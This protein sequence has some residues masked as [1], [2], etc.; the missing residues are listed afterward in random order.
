MVLAMMMCLGIFSI[1]QLS[2]VNDST[3]D[4]ATNWLPSVKALGS[5]N[6]IVGDFRRAEFRHVLRTSKEDKEKEEK[7]M[8]ATLGEIK[9]SMILPR[10][11]GQSEK[12]LQTEHGGLSW[13]Q[14]EDV[15]PA[16][17]RLKQSNWSL[18]AT[19]ASTRCDAFCRATLIISIPAFTLQI[20]SQL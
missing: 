7:G 14:E 13:Y 6:G 17:S 3:V 20:P 11:C 10:N 19:I 1:W 18:I 12:L 9:K 2:K 16:S 5:L 4:I 15:L 8:E